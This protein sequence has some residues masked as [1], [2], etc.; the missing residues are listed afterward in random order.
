MATDEFTHTE[1]Q[2]KLG[3][4]VRSRGSIP[5]PDG[6]LGQVVEV[7]FAQVRDDQPPDRAVFTIAWQLYP[8]YG[9]VPHTAMPLSKRQYQDTFRELWLDDAQYRLLFG[10]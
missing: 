7:R 4:I 9:A 3:Q 5:W 6:V 1:A 8:E 10:G 2:A